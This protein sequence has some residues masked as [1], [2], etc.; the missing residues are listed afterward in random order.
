MNMLKA[1][2]EYQRSKDGAPDYYARKPVQWAAKIDAKGKFV[3]WTDLRD[4]KGKG[5]VLAIPT[6]NRGSGASPCFLADTAE[7]VLG[8][9]AADRVEKI[10]TY[11]AAFVAQLG[12]AIADGVLAADI[13]KAALTEMKP[14]TGME[15][16]HIIVFEMP[17]TF[18][19]DTTDVQAWWAKRQEVRVGDGPIL[20]CSCCGEARKNVRLVSE[21]V[22]RVPESLQG[23]CA[24]ISSNSTAT[25][26]YGRAKAFGA[27]L[28]YPCVR[29][30]LRAINDL[31]N[32]PKHSVQVGNALVLTWG[33]DVNLVEASTKPTAATLRLLNE[34]SGQIDPKAETHVLVLSARQ[35]RAVV[36][37][38]RVHSSRNLALNLHRWLQSMGENTMFPLTDVWTKDAKGKKKKTPGLLPLLHANG[39]VKKVP[40][41]Y[42]VDL[43]LSATAATPLSPRFAGVA[44]V[45]FGRPKDD[46]KDIL[47]IAETLKRICTSYVEGIAMALNP[48]DTPAYRCGELLA[49]LEG[50]Q[51][52][53]IRGINRT[54]ADRCLRTT[55]PN[56]GAVLGRAMTDAKAHLAKLGRN[57]SETRWHRALAEVQQGLEF[58][59]RFDGRDQANFCLGYYSKASAISTR[60]EVA[61]KP[62]KAA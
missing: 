38:Y 8:Y 50:I 10:K 17:K 5:H 28:C 19:T 16:H 26:R 22:R 43:A 37:D 30:A 40:A 52:A 46:V 53:A 12:A 7:Y 15:G 34:L 49:V 56:P 31:I 27:S 29:D 47:P 57:G 25:E 3:G 2:V 60:P 21:W 13:V 45:V 42:A 51:K 54:V 41:A 55:A 1:L 24:L 4:A 61:K 33:V 36:R 14:P 9:G 48:A 35:S 44:D 59:H 32:D 23:K 20:P 11:H 6:V 18:V 62:E 39:N 58:P